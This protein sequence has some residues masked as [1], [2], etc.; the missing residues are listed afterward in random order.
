MNQ[1]VQYEIYQDIFLQY[2]GP[3]QIVNELEIT[4]DMN[5]FTHLLAYIRNSIIYDNM[6]LPYL[7]E[8]LITK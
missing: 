5:L 3:K 8:D 4:N 2:G 7:K 6:V 1:Y